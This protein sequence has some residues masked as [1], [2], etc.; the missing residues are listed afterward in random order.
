MYEIDINN[1]LQ[2]RGGSHFSPRDW[3]RLK[4]VIVL[5]DFS[6]YCQ[7]LWDSLFLIYETPNLGS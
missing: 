6:Y 7:S 1:S 2:K 4:R 5:C 3:P